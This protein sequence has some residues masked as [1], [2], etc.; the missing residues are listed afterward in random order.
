MKDL[1]LAIGI[2][3][4]VHVGHRMII[5][6]A[7]KHAQHDWSGVLT[8]HPHPK[9]VLNLPNAPQ[10]I[11]PIRQRYRLIQEL[12]VSRIF[13]KRFTDAWS[14]FCPDRFFEFL[15]R[16]FPNLNTI[17][18]GEDFRFGY[19]RQGDIHTLEALCSRDTH[20]KLDVTPNC[21]HDGER[22]C[23]TRIR[24]LL[25]EGQVPLMNLLLGKSYHRWATLK[26]SPVKNLYDVRFTCTYEASLPLGTYEVQLRGQ[27]DLS[28]AQCIVQPSGCQIALTR[29]PSK[30]P[31]AVIID[32]MRRLDK[33]MPFVKS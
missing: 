14:Q 11:Y 9:R 6:K 8:F 4:G 5:G 13:I 3:D 28:L 12:G 29:P 19:R 7:V 27:H 10:M 23:S 1:H 18:V 24:T 21:T 33:E 22:I 15:R 26:Q 16:I 20:V 31:C 2:F 32:F 25:H 17:Y 30:L